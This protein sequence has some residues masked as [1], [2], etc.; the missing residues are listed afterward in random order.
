M[1]TF[2]HCLLWLRRCIGFIFFYSIEV[3]LSN[4]RV[5]YDVLTP[6][7]RMDPAIIRLDVS[8]LTDR[9]RFFLSNL[10]TMTPGTLTLD[11]DA[12]AGELLVHAMY[13][14]NDPDALRAHFEKNYLQRIRH[15]F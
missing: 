8:G 12:T 3:V 2:L 5:A 9:Q 6:R 13:D 11:L 1:N 10:I 14:G 7:H 4:L 15:V